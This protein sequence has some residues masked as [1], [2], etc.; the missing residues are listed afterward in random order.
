MRFFIKDNHLIPTKDKQNSLPISLIPTIPQPSL[1]LDFSFNPDLQKLLT[2]KQL[3]LDDL[4]F[5]LEEIQHHYENG[6]ITYRKGIES[7]TE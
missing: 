7:S 6:Y 2:G 5:P 4:P 3:L 1:N